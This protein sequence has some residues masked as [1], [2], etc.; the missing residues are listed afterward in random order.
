MAAKRQTGL[1]FLDTDHHFIRERLQ[2]KLIVEKAKDFDGKQENVYV[3]CCDFNS[4]Q[5]LG[6]CSK[7]NNKFSVSAKVPC[8]DELVAAGLD[9]YLKG[10]Y[11]DLLLAEP[12]SPYGKG[13]KWNV[14]AQIDVNNPTAPA[15]ELIEKLSNIGRHI[16]AA[17]FHRALTALVEGTT[18]DCPPLNLAYRPTE[19]VFVIASPHVVQVIFS[20]AFVDQVDRELARVFT[21]EFAESGRVVEKAPGVNFYPPGRKPDELNGIDHTIDDNC[22]GYLVFA[23][24][25][26]H[27]DKPAKMERVIDLLVQFRSYLLYHIKCTKTELHSMMRKTYA[28]LIQVK[29]RCTPKGKTVHIK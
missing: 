4:I 15:E 9:D 7:K 25:K 19:Q 8:Y 14:T 10:I 21:V 26:M 20:L 1:V 12:N 17:P 11:G 18:A 16:F 22:I 6:H 27:V 13:A 2:R 23:V 24:S 29:E 3:T 28:N 5:L